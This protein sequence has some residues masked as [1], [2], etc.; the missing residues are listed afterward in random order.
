MAFTFDNFM[1]K[2]RALFGEDQNSDGDL[3]KVTRRLA[4]GVAT[5]RWPD[6]IAS[7][8][9]GILTRNVDSNSAA[10]SQ[11]YGPLTCFTAPFPCEIVKITM[12]LDISATVTN[13][14]STS[15]GVLVTKRGGS[16]GTGSLSAT[17]SISSF[18]GALTTDSGKNPTKSWSWSALTSNLAGV[19]NQF[20]LATGS[21][22]SKLKLGENDF[23]ECRITKGHSA[24]D[25]GARFAGGTLTIVYRKTAN[26]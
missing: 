9:D 25:T 15:F 1:N 5:W 21:A 7:N 13:T 24:D 3:D 4:E 16:N 18:I 10:L 11:P 14:A 8:A 19:P 22:A 17:R 6:A 23:L 26:P 2:V 12:A 20:H